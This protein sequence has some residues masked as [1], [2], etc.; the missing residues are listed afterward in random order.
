MSTSK[1]KKI[2]IAIWVFFT[3]FVIYPIVRYFPILG[4]I[5]KLLAVL[6][7]V[8]LIG[9]L[10]GLCFPEA[11]DAVLYRVGK[12]MDKLGLCTPGFGIFA[13]LIIFATKT[14]GP[15]IAL[16]SCVAV[17]T[18]GVVI[19]WFTAVVMRLLYNIAARGNKTHDIIGEGMK[20]YRSSG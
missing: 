20:N 7:L 19:F 2:G 16:P 3:P 8:S 6:C 13:S 18:I 10:I 9:A 17:A 4:V 14:Y 1:F 11:V 5:S 12:P 15:L